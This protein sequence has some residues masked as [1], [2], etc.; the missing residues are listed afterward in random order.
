M[1]WT[2]GRGGSVG[3]WTTDEREKALR[4]AVER[5]M[6][7]SQ[8]AAD[9]KRQFKEPITRNSVI[10]KA[11]RLGIKIGAGAGAGRGGCNQARSQKGQNHRMPAIKRPPAPLPLT[12]D[13]RSVTKSQQNLATLDPSPNP[14]LAPWRDRVEAPGQVTAADLQPHMCKWPIGDPREDS[15]TFCGRFRT[16]R[17]YCDEHQRRATG[18]TA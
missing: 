18:G 1:T 15:F 7:A 16:H 6:S 8:I 10:G 9:L 4:A 14:P 3:F 17:A 2:D 13:L 11:T 5:G 12:R